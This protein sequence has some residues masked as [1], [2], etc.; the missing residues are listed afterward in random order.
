M[1]RLLWPV[2]SAIILFTGC[3]EKDDEVV[4]TTAGAIPNAQSIQLTSLFNSSAA[5]ADDTECSDEG[6]NGL[7]GLAL[8]AACH[9]SPMAADLLIG[10]NTPENFSCD[11]YK[12][13]SDDE[14]GILINLICNPAF[15]AKLKTVLFNNEAEGEAIAISFA[16]FGPTEVAG[17]WSRG[18]AD[19]YPADIRIWFGDSIETLEGL[20]AIH[21]ESV[22][23]GTIYLTGFKGDTGEDLNW[24]FK[25]DY[26]NVA[27][28]SSCATSPSKDNCHSQ[29]IKIYTGEGAISDGPPNGFNLSIL[30]NS[31][32]NPDFMAIEGKYRYTEATAAGF[33]DAF[34]LE[35]GLQATRQIYLQTIKKDTQ[36]WGKFAFRDENDALLS[37]NVGSTDI[38]E[39]VNNGNCSNIG[40]TDEDF[41]EC[42]DIT[43]ADYDS[44]WQGESLMESITE[45]PVDITVGDAPTTEGFVIAE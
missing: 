14:Y 36:V 30:A 44:L 27:D 13:D 23:E 2:L 12:E 10:E 35:S 5:L 3:G 31:K 6:M 11:D 25:I 19:S 16:K 37:Y 21:L 28:T 8:G 34:A 17:Y 1:R 22:D 4:A 15:P 43:P 20:V 32:T 9:T 39:L 7:F 24:Q 26:K 29:D 33:N 42:T 18:S 45:T 38:F 41:D 40:D